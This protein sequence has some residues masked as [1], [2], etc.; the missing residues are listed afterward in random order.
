M[1]AHNARTLQTRDNRDRRIDEADHIIGKQSLACVI[2]T[3][4]ERD[5]QKLEEDTGYT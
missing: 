3:E 5:C 1:R 4:K 2:L